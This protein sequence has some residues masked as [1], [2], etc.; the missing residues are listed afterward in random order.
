MRE[1]LK[2]GKL[3]SFGGKRDGPKRWISNMGGGG[4]EDGVRRGWITN[5]LNLDIINFKKWIS[6]RR[7]RV[8]QSG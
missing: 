2:N 7:G 4:G 8:G 6:Q 3:S 1:V 5:I